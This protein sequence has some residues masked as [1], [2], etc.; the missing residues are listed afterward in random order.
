MRT[1]GILL[2]ISSLPSDYGIGTFGREAYRFVDFLSKAGQT[3]WQILPIGI[4]SFG[5][6]PYQSFSTFAGNPYFISLDKLIEEGV[7]TREECDSCDF[8]SDAQDIDYEKLYNVRYPL[9]R[10]AYER[11][12]I[13]RDSEYQRFVSE[14]SWWLADYALFMA[15]KNFFG[16]KCFNF[17]QLFQHTVFFALYLKLKIQYPP[18]LHIERGLN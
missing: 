2:H 13:S 3:Y 5:D 15:L 17:I 4:T 6:S 10:K 18:L 16:G 8:G 11:A 9:L 12:D 14:N 7:L 1:S